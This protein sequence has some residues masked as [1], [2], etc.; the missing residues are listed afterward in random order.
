MN[1]DYETLF[2]K[3]EFSMKNNHYK[4]NPLP[5]SDWALVEVYSISKH[6]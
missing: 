6:S 1:S 3:M 4:V 5:T 2:Y